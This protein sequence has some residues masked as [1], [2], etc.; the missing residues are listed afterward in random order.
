[1]SLHSLV[2]K[3]LHFL[4]QG[5]SLI[6]GW[7]TTIPHAK[8]K[9]KKEKLKPLVQV[10]IKDGINVYCGW[11][12]QRMGSGVKLLALEFQLPYLLTLQLSYAIEFHLFLPF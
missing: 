1:M 2:I 12:L 3:T 9:K 7:G 8:K 5:M 6:P 11:W 10:S 4:Y